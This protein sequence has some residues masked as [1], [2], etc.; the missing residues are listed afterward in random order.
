MRTNAKKLHKDISVRQASN[1][2]EADTSSLADL[3]GG[4]ASS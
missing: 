2:R 4:L 1:W 3:A